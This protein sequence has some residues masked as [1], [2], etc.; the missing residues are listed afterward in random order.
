MSLDAFV[1]VFLVVAMGLIA[2][3]AATALVWRVPRHI[4]WVSGRSACP[5]CGKPLGPLQLIPVFSW[6]FS[7]G[8]CRHCRE[9]I[10]VRYPVIELM[11][12]AWWL[13][14][15]FK[16]GIIWP[17]LPLAL[18]G[19]ILIALTWID[20]DFQL[21]PD[22]LT[23]PGTLIGVAA[24]LMIPNGARHA[25]WGMA[26]GAGLLW[27]LGWLY[28]KFRKVEGMGGGDVKLAAMFGAVLG[29]EMTLVTLFLAALAGSLW[30]GWL[31]LRR[32]GNGQTALPF[33]TLLA[34]AAMIA[35]LWGDVWMNA[36]LRI[37][38]GS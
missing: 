35:F 20:L 8:R 23:L 29:W 9:R 32:G 26:L 36:Y 16:I 31:I 38:H 17:Y 28:W 7:G 18:W 3:S 37:L 14:L 33:G 6:L 10:P 13:L 30:G 11:C 5:S 21:L 19:S 2:G 12:V 25:M 22:V 15:Y 24:A 1:V 4:S 27:L 34:P